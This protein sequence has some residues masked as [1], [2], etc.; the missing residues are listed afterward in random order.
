MQISFILKLDSSPTGVFPFISSLDWMTNG[1]WLRTRLIRIQHE[2]NQ[3]SITLV[4]SRGPQQTSL[5]TIQGDDCIKYLSTKCILTH[6]HRRRCRR[7]SSLEAGRSVHSREERVS[8]QCKSTRSPT[9]SFVGTFYIID[10]VW[11]VHMN[12]LS[13]RGVIRKHSL[14]K[15]LQIYRHN[16]ISNECFRIRF[17]L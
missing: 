15:D 14:S 3:G 6:H 1:G 12:E 17:I 10:Y 7:Q 5:L 16:Q 13:H 11:L 2:L 4:L 9:R 8:G